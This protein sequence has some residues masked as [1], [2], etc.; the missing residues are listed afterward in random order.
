MSDK[1]P[2]A[3]IP[4][5][6]KRYDVEQTV[7]AIR[8]A[9][10]STGISEEAGRI[11]TTYFLENIAAEL[12]KGRA[13]S[14]PGF[15]IFATTP[16]KNGYCRVRFSSH[17]ALRNEVAFCPTPNPDN[18]RRLRQYKNN[19]GLTSTAMVG[20]EHMRVFTAQAKQR[21]RIRAQFARRS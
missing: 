6:T 5:R 21:D 11:F 4:R 16:T 19:H 14:I 18:Q 2:V 17:R 15:G 1:K 3:R 8:N 9:A 10:S 20:G 13:C 12:A 7:R